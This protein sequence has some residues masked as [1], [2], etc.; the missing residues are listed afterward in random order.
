[1]A[2][3][4]GQAGEVVGVGVGVPALVVGGELAAEV[5]LDDFTALSGL[6]AGR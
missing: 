4:E 2:G 1:V 6:A 3:L 5:E